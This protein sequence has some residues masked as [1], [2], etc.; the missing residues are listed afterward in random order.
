M[1]L[2]LLGVLVRMDRLLWVILMDLGTRNSV[3]DGK[4]LACRQAEE[5][6]AEY[7]N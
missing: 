1:R 4:L 6:E 7:Q 5:W 3:L 2:R